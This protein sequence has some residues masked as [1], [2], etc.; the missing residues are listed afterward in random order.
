M[1]I[2]FL[3]LA[4]EEINNIKQHIKAESGQEK[5]DEIAEELISAIMRLKSSPTLGHIPRELH[6][7]PIQNVFEIVA[8]NST[9]RI[10]YEAYP[11]RIVIHIVCHYRRDMLN[12]LTKRML[13]KA[14][15]QK[16]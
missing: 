1:E 9:Y 14:R 10:I 11:K 16:K 3:K 8:V 5:A 12:L 2:Q 13:S 15:F 4:Q 6:N 7:F